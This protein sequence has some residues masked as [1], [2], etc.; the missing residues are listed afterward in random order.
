MTYPASTALIAA[1]RAERC[2]DAEDMFAEISRRLRSEGRRLAGVLQINA[3]REG[4]CRCD[5]KLKDLA[6]GEEICI[7]ED[8]GPD[9]RGALEVAAGR[10]NCAIRTGAEL[11]IVNKFGK[12]ESE[13]GGM[14][15]VIATALEYRI[16][17][18]VCANHE[19]HADLLAF[20]GD[21]ATAVPLSPDAIE[22][23][24]K[25]VLDHTT[26]SEAA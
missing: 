11:V 25:N 26:T 24:L 7:S 23:W 19:H 18:L 3:G 21:F 15:D 4:R 1:V 5:M 13:G 16:P 9:D 20:A 10:V 14:R 6:N 17:V 8:R 22:A 2:A 12:A